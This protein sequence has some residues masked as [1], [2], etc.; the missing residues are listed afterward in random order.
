MAP[1]DATKPAPNL[2][3]NGPR[4]IDCSAAVDVSKHNQI[5]GN[6]QE[7]NRPSIAVAAAIK[8][9]KLRLLVIK[10]ASLFNISAEASALL[11]EVM[12]SL[13]DSDDES[14][15][16][17]VKIFIENARAIGK[18]ANDFRETREARQ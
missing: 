7:K 11:D 9:A 15:F 4:N 10:R 16:E 1:P 13:E 3:G 2:P 14:F 8:R 6:R 17:H 12:Y 18:L 5:T